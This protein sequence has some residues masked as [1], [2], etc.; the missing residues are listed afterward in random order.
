[1]IGG[2]FAN[3]HCLRDS[4]LAILRHIPGNFSTSGR[5]ANVNRV[6]KVQLLDEFGDVGGIGVHLVTGDRLRGAPMSSPVVCTVALRL[7]RLGLPQTANGL[8]RNFSEE[9]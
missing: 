5:M 1:M 7:Q 6:P 8:A 3:Q 9:R 2:T 4:P